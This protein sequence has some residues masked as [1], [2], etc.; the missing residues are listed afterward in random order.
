MITTMESLP[1]V[2]QGL[3]GILLFTC[4]VKIAT[5]F[6][7][8]RFGIGLHDSAFGLVIL[9]V[10]LALTF[11]V[12][13]PQ[14]SKGSAWDEFLGD[15]SLQSQSDLENQFRPFLAAHADEKLTKRLETLSSKMKA[16]KE[17]EEKGDS[18]VEV[19]VEGSPEGEVSL[20]VLSSSFLLTELRTA[21]YIGLLILIP[22]LVIDLLVTNVLMTLGVTQMPHA[23]VALPLKLLTFF[24]LDGWALI[25]EKIISGYT[26]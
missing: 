1:A 8:L 6:S 15:G 2:F 5:T 3:L 23:V 18:E 13:E 4:F 9:A 24:A 19:E 26:M 20:Y 12:M 16:K 17:V 21:F 14:L 22:F 10:S 7:I 11:L 25:T